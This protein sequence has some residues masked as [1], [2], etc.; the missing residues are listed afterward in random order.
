MA[1]ELQLLD[2][3]TFIRE[4]FNHENAQYFD[5]NYVTEF[6]Q[7]IRGCMTDDQAQ[8]HAKSNHDLIIICKTGDIKS[9]EAKLQ[10]IEGQHFDRCRAIPSHNQTV[11]LMA[12]SD[13]YSTLIETQNFGPLLHSLFHQN[14]NLFQ[15]LL[16]KYCF[17]LF[18]ELILD[19]DSDS[20]ESTAGQTNTL[21][22]L[23]LIIDRKD[24]KEYSSAAL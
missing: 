6:K 11:D 7:F 5:S 13:K 1:A 15:T 2:T 14:I 8:E 18:K 16:H 23:L 19:P 12:Q 10:K 9:V 3:E 21:L 4:I 20:G 17:N 22:P 24:D